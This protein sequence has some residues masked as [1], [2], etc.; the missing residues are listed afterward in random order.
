MPSYKDLR[1]GL[2]VGLNRGE[3][4]FALGIIMGWSESILVIETALRHLE[5]I[6]RIIMGDMIFPRG[7][8]GNGGIR[9]IPKKS[10]NFIQ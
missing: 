2:V 3:R 8:S 9:D 10:R 5:Q 1:R 4:T 7:A 6:D